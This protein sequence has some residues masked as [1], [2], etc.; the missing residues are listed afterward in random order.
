M[1]IPLNK[2]QK[3]VLIENYQTIRAGNVYY[4]A[5]RALQKCSAKLA[6]SPS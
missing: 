5:Q 4:F 6:A 1:D 2:K 3:Q